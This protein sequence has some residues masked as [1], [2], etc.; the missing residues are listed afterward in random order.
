MALLVR[1]LC[2]LGLLAVTLPAAALNGPETAVLLNQAYRATPERC[3]GNFPAYY[4]SG[5]M[6]KQVRPEDPKP[7]WIHSP[8]AVGRGAE[9]FDY[10]RRD[11]PGT[12]LAQPSGYLFSDRFTAISQEKDYQLQGD[13]GMNRPP[14]LLVRNWGG[15]AP[16][17]LPLLGVFH[18]LGQPGGLEAALRD[19]RAYFEA[20]GDWLPV[21]RLKPNDSQGQLFGFD[22]REQLYSGYQVADRLNRRYADTAP[23]CND[24][25]GSYNCNG[26][27]IRGTV[28]GPPHSWN[29]KP[30]A[31]ADKGVS[32]S[33]LRA[34]VGSRIIFYGQGFIFR[35]LS[36]PVSYP[37][38]LRC[39]YPGDAGTSAPDRC[40]PDCS[41]KG[42]KTLA[43]YRAHYP[44]SYGGD[45]SLGPDAQAFQLNT[46][47]RIG[48]SWASAVWNEIII[49]PWTLDIP[50]QI[51]LEAFFYNWAQ[52]AAGLPGAQYIQR[53]YYQVTGKFMPVVK[54]DLTAPVGAVFT[55][56]P[57]E[58]GF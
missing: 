13:D 15:V 3:V 39:A 56:D 22:A 28:P 12:P 38:T 31:I 46:D 1:L 40:R 53:D 8:E 6:V 27:L 9:Q 36:F 16:G 32:F 52:S 2:A 54:I 17:R 25:S 43:D 47:V 5:V 14:Q 41:L 19:Q 48:Q 51:P 42:I 20:T 55:F 33:Y 11:V 23:A 24:G 18:V 29:P 30:N 34:D 35:E 50:L 10:L 58:Q 37:V 44:T 21:L 57:R 45:C 7:F 26:V 49:A 4:C